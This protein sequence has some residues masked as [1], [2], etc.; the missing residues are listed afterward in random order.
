MRGSDH[1]ATTKE[2]VATGKDCHLSVRAP[3]CVEQGVSI[4]N[5]SSQ[6]C[7]PVITSTQVY[8]SLTFA[9]NS[10]LIPSYLH[11]RYYLFHEVP[12]LII[13]NDILYH[14]IF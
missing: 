2:L 11:C 9:A 6:I 10:D 5:F 13:F 3:S 7:E 8:I 12:W 14:T 1:P 4:D